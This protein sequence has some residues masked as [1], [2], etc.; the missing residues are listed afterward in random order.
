MVLAFP[1]YAIAVW[2]QIRAVPLRAIG[3]A[4]IG[5]LFGIPAGWYNY[6]RWGTIAD[7][8]FPKFYRIMD[9]GKFDPSPPFALQNVAMQLRFYFP[10]AAGRDRPTRR[11]SSRACSARR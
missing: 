11:I 2:P 6:V 5:A 10:A 9:I 4:A 8:G 7:V 3:V 1:A